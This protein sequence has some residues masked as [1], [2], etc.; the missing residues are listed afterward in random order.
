VFFR[1]KKVGCAARRCALPEIKFVSLTC[2]ATAA[3]AQPPCRK[4]CMPAFL[5]AVHI[6]FSDV[7]RGIFASK[8]DALPEK[9]SSKRQIAVFPARFARRVTAPALQA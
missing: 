3:C 8:K 1:K 6:H 2:L 5:P 7:V 4:L 9:S